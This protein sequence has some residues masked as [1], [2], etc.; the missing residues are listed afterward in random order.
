MLPWAGE[1]KPWG[2]H[3]SR[4]CLSDLVHLLIHSKFSYL[5]SVGGLFPTALRRH[6]YFLQALCS[7]TGS[8]LRLEFSVTTS[9]PIGYGL[10]TAVLI[11][12][13]HSCLG[14]LALVFSSQR[15]LSHKLL[16]QA[17]PCSSVICS[18]RPSLTCR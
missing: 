17:P 16:V 5:K 12:Q 18:D 14:A 11:H 9:Y 3:G 10:L 15:M 8:G 13:D 6:P 2:S 7:P 4:V 1:Q